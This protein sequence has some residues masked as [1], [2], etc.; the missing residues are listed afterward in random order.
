MKK[1]NWE[2]GLVR[3]A[4]TLSILAGIVC[5]L[6]FLIYGVGND[7]LALFIVFMLI[8][9]LLLASTYPLAKFCFFF[10]GIVLLLLLML[11]FIKGFRKG[12]LDK[13]Q[14]IGT[15]GKRKV[16]KR[17]IISTLVIIAIVGS[18]GG[19]LSYYWY[20]QTYTGPR[21]GGSVNSFL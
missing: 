10:L 20:H 12:G 16:N 3:I 13:Q 14:A 7:I 18:G 2:R 9:P 19:Y 6:A 11:F 1:I 5:F 8:A 21:S 17:I 15:T 4:W